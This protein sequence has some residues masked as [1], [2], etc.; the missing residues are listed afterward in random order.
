MME[1]AYGG[2]CDSPVVCCAGRILKF[3]WLRVTALEVVLNKLETDTPRSA[4][5]TCNYS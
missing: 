4:G 2:V 5:L 1:S 3:S